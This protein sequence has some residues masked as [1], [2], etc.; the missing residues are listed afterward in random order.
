M[1]LSP[2]KLASMIGVQRSGIS[3][4]LSGRNK[5]S[6]DFIEKFL[7]A[8]PAVNAEWLITGKGPMM[9]MSGT[10][11]LFDSTSGIREEAAKEDNSKE[12]AFN[13]S[14]ESP[15]KEKEAVQRP[16][17][18]EIQQVMVFFTDGTVKVYKPGK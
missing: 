1:D 12:P 11:D 10:T 18:Q 13:L 16:D 5:P 17:Q 7:K 4:I 8:F 2:G 9:K 3:H 15:V 6:L 14:E